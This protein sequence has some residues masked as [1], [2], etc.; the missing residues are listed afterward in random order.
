[1]SHRKSASFRVDCNKI[2]GLEVYILPCLLPTFALGPT[3]MLNEHKA[4]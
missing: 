3:E 4:E 2:D 1:M